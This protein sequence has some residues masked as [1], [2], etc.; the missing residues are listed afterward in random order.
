MGEKMNKVAVLT[1][2]NCGIMQEEAQEIGLYVIAMPFYIN[3]KIYYEGVDL[4]QEEFYEKL[5]EECEIK[6]SMPVLGDV[7]DIWDELLLEYDEIVYIP[8]SSGLSGSYE[9]ANML[10]FDDDYEGR[11]FVVNNQRIS[12]TMKE[13]VMDAL[14]MAQKGYSA[15]KIKEILEEHKM[16]SSIYISL[17]SIKYLSKGG[18]LTPAVAALGKILKIK[19]VLQIQGDKLD[20]FAKARTALQCKNIMLE[21][22]ENDIVNR[23]D[24]DYSNVVIAVSHTN[25]EEEA[26]K[27]KKEVLE[28]WPNREVVLDPLPLSI[29]CHIGPGSL[30]ITVGR[31]I[32]IE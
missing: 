5:E 20:S 14:L 31:R 21:A 11:V 2:S 6:T 16:E 26:I 15:S 12:V 9:A 4:T 10:S 30:A 1:D 17:P 23:F 22:I 3:E 24:S 8:M 13:S 27:L 18:R 7:L 19:P 32:T 29:A 28:K 25:N